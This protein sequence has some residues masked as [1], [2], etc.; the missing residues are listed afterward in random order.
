MARN[1]STALIAIGGAVFVVGAALTF[2]AM[3]GDDGGDVRATTTPGAGAAGQAE[4]VA[5]AQ[6]SPPVVKIPDGMEAVAVQ[7]PPIPGLAGYLKVGDNVNVY[8]TFKDRQPTAAVKGPPLAKLI[9]SNVEVLA[10]T[11]GA[12][13]APGTYLLAVDAIQAEQIIYLVSFESVWLSLTRE[14]APDVTNTPGRN[15]PNAVG[16]GA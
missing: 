1:R 3:R 6:A 2:L 9:T 13:G 14:G 8:G 10:V 7:V 5:A 12:E 16:S 15:A 4:P 11:A